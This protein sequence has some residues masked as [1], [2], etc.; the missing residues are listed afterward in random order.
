M[1]PLPLPGIK[2][3]A[4]IIVAVAL[5]ASHW[6]AYTHGKR[7]VQSDWNKAVASDQ[8]RSAERAIANLTQ[9]DN[10]HANR[11]KTIAANAA[12]ADR[13]RAAADSLRNNSE[14]SL[15]TARESHAACVVSAAIHAELLGRCE[16]SYRGMAEKA[17]GHATD[18]KALVESWP[19]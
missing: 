15:A 10:A 5:A 4:S 1:I 8:I 11:T 19:K 6:K 7:A 12:A 18:V 9:R 2:T 14:R 3:V 17:Q 13:A 16:S